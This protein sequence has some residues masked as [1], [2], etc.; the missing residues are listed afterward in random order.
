MGRDQSML[1]HIHQTGELPLQP[2]Y[3]AQDLARGMLC[4]LVTTEKFAQEM[5]DLRPGEAEALQVVLKWLL[6]QNPWL[7]GYQ[8]SMRDIHRTLED[9]RAHFRKEGRLLPGVRKIMTTKKKTS[10]NIIVKFLR[11]FE[12]SRLK[13][14]V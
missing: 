12:Y 2:L 4:S 6:D 1:T 11:L 9:L 7:Q 3:P 10:K 13:M 14:I 5:F 8:N